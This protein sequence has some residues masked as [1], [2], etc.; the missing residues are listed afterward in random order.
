MKR[1]LF[2]FAKLNPGLRYIQGM[3]ELFAPLYYMFKTDPDRWGRRTAWAG[4]AAARRVLACHTGHMT[5]AGPHRP[6]RAERRPHV[7]G[8]PAPPAALPGAPSVCTTAHA[9]KP[10]DE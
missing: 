7:R 9:Q 3:N 8:I 6:L 10:L 2:L 1:A 4:S 5:L